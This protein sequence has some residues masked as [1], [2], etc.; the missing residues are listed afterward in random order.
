MKF[1]A[2]PF[3]SSDNR[4]I[5][6]KKNKNERSTSQYIQTKRS[7]DKSELRHLKK[8][9]STITLSTVDAK[10]NTFGFLPFLVRRTQGGPS[11]SS[12]EAPDK[13]LKETK[14]GLPVKKKQLLR[15]TSTVI[16]ASLKWQV[17]K[18]RPKI[19]PPKKTEILRARKNT[20]I[21]C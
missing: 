12:T 15:S 17:Q 9:L 18:S 16:L 13:Y 19:F 20:L 10:E 11:F 8:L 6:R 5:S 1:L 2:F 21:P 3:E 14:I 7:Q 4:P